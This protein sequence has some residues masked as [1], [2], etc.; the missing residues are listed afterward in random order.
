MRF[1]KRKKDD[2]PKLPK[3]ELL[4]IPIGSMIELSDMATFNL[5][6][7]ATQSFELKA[8]KKYEASGFLRYI[9]DLMNGEEIFLG[10]DVNTATG[11]CNLVRFVIDSE[12]EFEEPLEDT[13]NME[14]EDPEGEDGAITVE[15]HRFNVTNTKMTLVSPDGSEEHPDVEL[16]DFEEED[17]SILMVELW[18]DWFT[19]YIGEPIE[20]G[21]VNV[22]RI[23]PNAK[24]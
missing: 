9:Y 14:F 22:F 4:D 23:D 17:G 6:E 11:E 24:K 10:V 19:F 5:E 2:E 13:I 16:Q 3:N 20:M 15:Y 7:K 21:N 8:Y 18:N 1:F 12:E